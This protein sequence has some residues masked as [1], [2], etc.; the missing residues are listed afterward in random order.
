VCIG[1]ARSTT[2][3]VFNK[4]R[5]SATIIDYEPMSVHLRYRR[6]VNACPFAASAS[7]T[8]ENAHESRR[9]IAF[10]VVALGEFFVTPRPYNRPARELDG[11]LI[12]F[13]R[14]KP[15]RT[16]SGTPSKRTRK[17]VITTRISA[18]V[19]IFGRFFSLDTDETC[20][21]RD[22]G[23]KKSARHS[24]PRPRAAGNT[25]H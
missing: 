14:T 24:P 12:C 22:N 13:V 6:A 8:D 16:D 11:G 21:R 9:S 10:F 25:E 20:V 19:G 3:R 1:N 15:K 4:C 5:H 2:D 18:P 23:E 7:F 17:S